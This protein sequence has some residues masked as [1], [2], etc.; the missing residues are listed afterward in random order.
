LG[1]P[2]GRGLEKKKVVDE[3]LLGGT[4]GTEQP[5]AGGLTG[6]G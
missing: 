3:G 4:T 5:S 6:K 2:E 1:R